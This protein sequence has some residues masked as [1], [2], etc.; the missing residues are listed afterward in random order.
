MP[1]EVY[2]HVDAIRLS[3]GGNELWIDYC[4]WHE[5]H[6][7][8]HLRYIIGAE[9]S[10]RLVTGGGE[11]QIAVEDIPQQVSR[12]ASAWLKST[13]EAARSQQRQELAD[14]LATLLSKLGGLRA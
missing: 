9:G 7:T 11:R 13:A 4:D 12:E 6:E 5:Q 14:M 8:I 3:P 2:S 1:S 10:P